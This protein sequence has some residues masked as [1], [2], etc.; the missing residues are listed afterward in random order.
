MTRRIALVILTSLFATV[1]AASAAWAYFT[2]TATG[3]GSTPIGTLA[4]PTAVSGTPG[5][6]LVDVTWTGVT[7]PGLD[8]VGYYVTRTPAAGGSAVD[9][10]GSPSALLA[11]TPTAC[12]DSPAP[13]G[14]FTYAV[15]AAYGSWTSTSAASDDVAV[16]KAATATSLALS[17]S[18]TSYG[19]EGSVTFTGS[20]VPGAS[21]TPTGSITV[22][23]G[24]TD[25]CTITLP[26]T[27]C[28][29]SATTLGASGSAYGVH[30]TYS[31]D[32]E[33]TGSTSSSHDLTVTK[34]STTTTVA[35]VPDTVTFGYES[36]T[37]L[38][39]SVTTGNGEAL[40]AT[41]ETATVHAGTTS[42][43][44]TLTPGGSGA[45]GTCSIAASNLGI[46]GTP[47]DVT[48]TYTGDTDLTSSTATAATGLTVVDVPTVITSSLPAATQTQVGYSQT[49]ASAGGSSPISWSIFSGTLPTGLTLDGASG[50]ISGTV[51]PAALTE[52]FTVQATDHSGATAQAALTITVYAAPIITTTSLASARAA[53][54]GYSQTL[55]ATG[56]TPDLSWSVDTGVL[57][58]GLALDSATGVISGTLGSSDAT[59]TFT[60]IVF[61]ANGL[62]D[63]KELTITV[64]N[65]FV[66]Q[67]TT[68][69]AGNASSFQ[70][71]LSNGVG[72][73][74]ALVLSVSQACTRT[75]STPA[76]AVDSHVTGVTG[77]SLT[78]VK[79]TAT[80]C[81]ANGDAEVWYGLG[82]TAAGA[83]TKI[84]VS[85]NATAEVQYANVAEYAGVTGIDS[86]SGATA[87]ASASSSTVSP[88]SST[89]SAAGELVVSAAYTTL[90]TGTSLAGLVDPFVPLNLVSPYRG[91]GT[92][93][94]YATTT[95]LTYSFT[96]KV[97]GT[98]T[99]GSWAS[100]ITAFTL[101]S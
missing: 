21:F 85:L 90:P 99:A 38:T 87:S 29:T 54:T 20:V 58:N 65:P 91:F 57:P 78:W 93:A 28:A 61:D 12:T 1:V 22:T 55:A 84:T 19:G 39:V 69:P 83:G 86:A 82:T 46:S 63:T 43:V 89:P 51:D 52:S 68:K 98:P 47:Y 42:C 13:A 18:S 26:D 72:A 74:H 94:V 56:G 16:S 24:S 15:T 100:V 34:D 14:T 71:T 49:L 33:F 97:G 59:S 17:A 37:A 48:T 11:A 8:G 44:A 81:S 95:P 77:D 62:S 2:S 5:V 101:S 41:G 45:S 73:G 50:S 64:T 27:T 7:A 4:A 53:E 3:S 96:Q 32:G 70:V 31:G 67:S 10:C 66:R 40:P 60:V 35:A 92:Y 25:L 30:A 75:S 76:T 9:V 79:A 6:G 36:A 80:G 23:T 88:G